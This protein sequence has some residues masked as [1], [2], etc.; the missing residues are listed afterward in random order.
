VK[1]K[2]RPLK[3]IEAIRGSPSPCSVFAKVPIHASD[4]ERRDKTSVRPS[5]ADILN[6]VNEVGVLLRQKLKGVQLLS[7]PQP[8]QENLTRNG[9]SPN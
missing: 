9:D 2:A 8:S 4:K 6:L 3:A 1:E 5:L 7:P